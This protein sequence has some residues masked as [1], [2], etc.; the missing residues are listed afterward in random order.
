M[1][2]TTSEI[3][4]YEVTYS[5]NGNTKSTIVRAD[6]IKQ[7]PNYVEFYATH[8]DEIVLTFSVSVSYLRMIKNLTLEIEHDLDG[9]VYGGTGNQN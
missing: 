1:N 3:Y 9:V 4:T 2:I 8:D 6:E 5:E 7:F